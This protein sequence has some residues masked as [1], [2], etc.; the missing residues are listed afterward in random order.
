MQS[1]V[2]SSGFGVIGENGQHPQPTDHGVRSS[3]PITIPSNLSIGRRTAPII[4]L[5]AAWRVRWAGRCT[6]W[7]QDI[8]RNSYKSQFPKFR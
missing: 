3:L 1:I 2:I 8:S 4:L 6:A 5:S 7:N